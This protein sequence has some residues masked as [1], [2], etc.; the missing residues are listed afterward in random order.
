MLA[1]LLACT[2]AEPSLDLQKSLQRSRQ[3]TTES[4]QN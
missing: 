3:K 1:L 4:K 2:N